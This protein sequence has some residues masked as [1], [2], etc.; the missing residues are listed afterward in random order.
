[1]LWRWQLFE[2]L[3]GREMHDI[4]SLRQQV[5]V[6]EQNCVYLDADDLDRK[7]WHLTARTGDGEIG[8]YVRLTC[9]GSRFT[10][11]SIGRLLTRETFRR[12]GFAKTAVEK[13]IAKCTREYPSQNIRISAQAYLIRFYAKLGFI[14]TGAPY[15]EDG[16]EHIDMILEM[17]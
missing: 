2:E 16:I 7:S 11:P 17:N 6:V 9:P 8:V 5:F 12:K 4:L 14:V 1:M 3:T 13:V 10:E 15:D